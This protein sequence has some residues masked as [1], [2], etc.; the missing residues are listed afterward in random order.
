MLATA[1]AMSSSANPEGALEGAKFASAGISVPQNSSFHFSAQRGRVGEH[2]S[3]ANEGNIVVLKCSTPF[4]ARHVPSTS[5]RGAPENAQ[6][7]R[8]PLMPAQCRFHRV[9]K[10]LSHA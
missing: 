6:Q 7:N 5:R 4:T 2:P 9:T 10:R 1:C 8:A 3:A